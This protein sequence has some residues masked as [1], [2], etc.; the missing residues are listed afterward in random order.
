[1]TLR[2]SRTFFKSANPKS[3]KWLLYSEVD[4]TALKR[5]KY[6]IADLKAASTMP[7]SFLS[8]SIFKR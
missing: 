6:L 3:L 5:N 7:K 2:K 1:M 4:G 8:V